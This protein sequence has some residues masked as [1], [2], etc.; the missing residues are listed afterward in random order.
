[1][2]QHFIVIGNP[3]SHSK[4]P[5]IHAAFARSVGLSVSYQKQYCPNDADSFTAVVSA[6]FAGGGVGANITL[7]FKEMAFDMIKSNGRLSTHALAAGAVNTILQ[8]QQGL[9]GDNTDGR[10]LVADLY[11]QAIKLDN[12]KI[13]LIGAGG[14]ARGV[15][16][17]LLEAGAHI[18]IFNR[19]SLKA[20]NLVNEFQ[21][22]KISAHLLDELKTGGKFDVIINATS[23][24]TTG[25]ILDLGGCSA[26]FAYD[27]M[28][29]KPSAFLTHFKQQ[30]ADISDGFGMLIQ[31]AKLSFEQWTGKTIDLSQVQF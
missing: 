6:F 19:T 29:G 22:D 7:P 15:I 31:Q 8:D 14:A 12:K 28:Y 25:Q 30:G 13:A 9:Y 21:S 27:M 11:A 16:L 1:M 10:G 3:I 26:S 24:T 2:M 18:S 17:P 23:A 4:S 5:Q 20:I